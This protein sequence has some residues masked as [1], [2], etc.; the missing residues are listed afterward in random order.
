M[1]DPETALRDDLRT[2]A[3][4][5]RGRGLLQLA[6]RGIQEDGRD[7]TAGCW[8]DSGIAGCLFQHAYWQGVR[9][10]VFPAERRAAVDW[11]SAY[12]GRELY[13]TVIRSIGDFDELAKRDYLTRCVRVLPLQ[14]GGLRT[15]AWRTTVERM[16]VEA[17]AEPEAGTP[18][19]PQRT[20]LH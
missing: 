19:E 7:L 5:E 6:L 11:V 2:L 17:L 16:L 20:A 12:A 9:Q 8:V 10:G 4:H 1:D 3:A 18:R 14:R 13:G 15:G